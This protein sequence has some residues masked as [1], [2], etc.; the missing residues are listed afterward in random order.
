[1]SYWV[2]SDLFEEPGPP[3]APFH[4]GFGLLNYQDLPKPSFYAYHFLHRLGDRLQL[5]VLLGQPHDL[6]PVRGRAHARLDLAEAVE[7]LVE[8]GLGKSQGSF[9]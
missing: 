4:G 1:M 2:Y 8:T 7:H 5:C 9:A 6:G 3:D